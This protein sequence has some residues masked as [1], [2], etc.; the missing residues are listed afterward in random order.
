MM[1]LFIRFL[2]VINMFEMKDLLFK[3]NLDKRRREEDLEEVAV[4]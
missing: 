1:W 4:H 3:Q 2:P